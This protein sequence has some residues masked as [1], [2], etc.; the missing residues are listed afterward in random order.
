LL[1]CYYSLPLAIGARASQIADDPT[2]FV[3]GPSHWYVE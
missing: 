2:P 3:A 1:P